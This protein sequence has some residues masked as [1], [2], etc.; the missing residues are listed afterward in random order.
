LIRS[1]EHKALR[2]KAFEEQSTL[3][4][5]QVFFYHLPAGTT[6]KPQKFNDHL[7]VAEILCLKFNIALKPGSNI[8][9]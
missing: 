7:F 3:P 4:S 5:L 9:L 6:E 2:L 8:M 1:A